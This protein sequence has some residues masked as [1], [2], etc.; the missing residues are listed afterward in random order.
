MGQ[1]TEL[2]LGKIEAELEEV[3][4]RKAPPARKRTGM[5]RWKK[6][7]LLSVGAV[8]LIS[9]VLGGIAWSKRGVVTVQ[10]G[11]VA[12]QELSSIVSASGQIRPPSAK[13]ANVNA[14]TYGKITEILVKEGDP[15][16][17]G[18]ILLKTE[19]VQQEA[20]VDAQQAALKTQLA[21][22]SAAEA[23]V[24]SS[25]ASLKTVQAELQTAQ[26]N[27][28]RAREDW[29]RA[30]ELLKDRLI[31]QQLYDQRRSD[32]E[33]AQANVLAAEARVT[34]AKAQYQQST[35]NRDM[36][37]ARVAQNRAALV[38]ANDLRAKTIYASPL[39]GIVTAL[40]V[41]VGENVVLGIQNS[42]GSLLYQVSDLSTI[43]AEVKVDETDIVNVKLGQPAE[44]TIDAVRNK[45]FKGHV[46]EIGQN[47]VGRTSGLTSGQSST[48]T[49]EAKDFKVVVTLDDPPPGLRPGLS[50]TAKITTATRQDAVAIPIQALAV[51]MRRDLEESE[52]E[53][54]GKGKESQGKVQAA[55]TQSTPASSSSKEKDKGKEEIQGVFVLKNGLAVFTPVETGIMGTT[56]M[57][58]LSGVKPGDEIV[59]GSF[60]VLRTLKNNTKVKVDNSAV[61]AGGP[62]A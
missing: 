47:A 42:P 19:S 33:V 46:T 49:E 53:G 55:A 10:T 17:K 13:F 28:G 41:H 30:Q 11:K 29:A 51:R 36:S 45:T 54:K 61:K 27:F 16:K 58:V 6:A 22:V 2:G 24:Q 40:P 32:F 39:D 50:T 9:L 4:A 3:E 43:T 20:D 26:A 21:D 25:S 14:N 52:K 8:V 18:Q 31:A 38:R 23:G 59:T 44:V 34:Q 5:K 62:S 56:D 35:Y 37:R 12:K 57:E 7:L 1:T 48:T 60:S 15:V